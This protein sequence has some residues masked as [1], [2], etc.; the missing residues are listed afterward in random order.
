MSKLALASDA[1]PLVATTTERGVRFP[2]P[3]TNQRVQNLETARYEMWNGSSWVNFTDGNLNGP[4]SS[5]DNA[6]VRWDGTGGVTIQNS[7][8]TISD[9]G[10]LTLTSTTGP[11]LV[12]RYDASTRLD[13]TVAQ[14]TGVVTYASSVSGNINT[15]HYFSNAVEVVATGSTMPSTGF[16]VSAN[17]QGSG[18]ESAF[19]AMQAVATWISSGTATELV[20]L[21]TNVIRSTG[22][23]TTAI[24]QKVVALSATCTT[25]YGVYVDDITGGGTNYALYTKSGLV[26]FGGAVNIA[27]TNGLQVNGTKVIGAQGAAVTDATGAGDVVA[28][29]NDLL[30]RLRTHGLIAT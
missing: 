7:P 22:T 17:K 24:S 8:A 21:R 16:V 10:V 25:A 13:V 5:T 6:I 19:A 20:G 11:Q 3:D 2:T 14:T 9:A 30:A 23:V 29:L 27:T 1:I 12:V 4:V 18:N 26:R 28:Q 15:R